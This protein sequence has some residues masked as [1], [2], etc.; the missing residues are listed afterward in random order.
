MNARKNCTWFTLLTR[1]YVIN[2]HQWP[3]IYAYVYN[4]RGFGEYETCSE[5]RSTVH[6]HTHSHTH[7]HTHT[8]TYTHTYTHTHTHIH[9]HTH[10]PTHTNLYGSSV[11]TLV[12]TVRISFNAIPLH[13]HIIASTNEPFIQSSDE[14]SYFLLTT[15]GVLLLSATVSQLF[16]NH[17]QICSIQNRVSSWET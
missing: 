2:E 10:T 1:M 6:T 16:P 4:M 13:F 12:R 14:R 3:I 8:Y 9:A 7:T 15:V 11:L 17:F 5:Y